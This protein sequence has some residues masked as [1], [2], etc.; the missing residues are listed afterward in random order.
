MVLLPA[1]SVFAHRPYEHVAGTFQRQDG[2]AIFIVRHYVDG[3]VLADPVSVQFR[4]PDGTQVAQT[5]HV[6]DTV[7]RFIPSGVEVYQ[8]RTTW[9]PLASSVEIF[10]GYT[11]K[12]ITSRRRSVSPLIHFESHWLCYLVAFGFGICFVGSWLALRAVPERGWRVPLRRV[13]FAFVTIAGGLFAYDML[14]FEPV[15]PLVLAGGGFMFGAAID[16]VRK[17]TRRSIV[18]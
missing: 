9:L 14:V 11:L 4:L 1:M 16:Y 7:V 2:T 3:I 12:D 18:G 17:R 6:S 5:P 10:D 15:S 13:G 8:F